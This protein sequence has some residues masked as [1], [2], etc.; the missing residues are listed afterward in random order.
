MFSWQEKLA[1][2]KGQFVERCWQRLAEL[3]ELVKKLADDPTDSAVLRQISQHF[4][5]MAGA[6]GIYEMNDFC[7]LC[8]EAEDFVRGLSGPQVNARACDIERLRGILSFIESSLLNESRP[9]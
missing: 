8:I 4:H 3:G 6:G 7:R 5:Q 2:R 9:E 1:R